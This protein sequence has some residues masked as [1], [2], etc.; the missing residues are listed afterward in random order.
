MSSSQ[1]LSKYFFLP[2]KLLGKKSKSFMFD[3]Y[4]YHEED[5]NISLDTKAHHRI[6]QEHLDGYSFL[7]G[8][9]YKI[10]IAIAQKS[11]CFLELGIHEKDLVFDD[12][13]D[14]P[15]KELALN[16][17]DQKAKFEKEI[18][19]FDFTKAWKSSLR[20]NNYEQVIAMA[21]K[22]IFCFPLN[23]SMTVS[24]AR[25]LSQFL[26]KDNVNN[27][28]I[29]VTYYFA[30]MLGITGYEELSDLICAAFFKDLGTL[31]LNYGFENVP[32]ETLDRSL[33]VD[34][35]K[36]PKISLF[37]LKKSGIEL[38]EQCFKIIEQHHETP[39]G[40]GF[41]AGLVGASV[42]SLS[43]LLGVVDQFFRFLGGHVTKNK[44]S[45]QDIL[46]LWEKGQNPQGMKTYQEEMAKQ[47]SGFLK[48]S[49]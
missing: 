34:Y 1:D 42:V 47:F 19:E 3:I 31:F 15:D 9:G 12:G 49:A 45:H 35:F 41:P 5:K 2:S 23:V 46:S 25:M 4:I 17:V 24:N 8:K 13:V 32:V 48:S 36:H 38:S 28:I 43:Q 40:A 6:Q 18:H 11:I 37:L 7:E 29:S 26:E 33:Q 30:K 10:A 22:E 27:R 14:G 20:T 16:Y 44:L 39:D 21:K